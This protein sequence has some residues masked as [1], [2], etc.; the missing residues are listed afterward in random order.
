MIQT[1][2]KGKAKMEDDE[3]SDKALKD[4]DWKPVQAVQRY[5]KEQKEEYGLDDA[6]SLS[7][8]ILAETFLSKFKLPSLDKYDRTTDPRSHL[9]IFRTMI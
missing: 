4:V 2:S 7:K 9:A 6:S 5:Q 8:E 3:S 1:Q